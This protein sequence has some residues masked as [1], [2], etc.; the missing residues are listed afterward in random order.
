MGP[1]HINEGNA[2]G[3][4][5][6]KTIVVATDGSIDGDRAVASAGTLAAA[7]ASRVVVVHVT[8]VVGGRGGAVPFAADEDELRARINSQVS[9]LKAAGVPADLLIHT[10]RTGGP[11]R[12]IAEDAKAV[13]ADLIIVG[14]RGRSAV[15]QMF[16]GSV[17]VRLLH[18]AHCPVL[19]VPPPEPAGT[20]VTPTLSSQST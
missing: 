14:W 18:V 15:S 2:K 4:N 3:I 7:G 16:L 11:A 19:V 6:F 9:E 12:D 8:E 20:A 17:I 13:D 10:L 1:W 5:M